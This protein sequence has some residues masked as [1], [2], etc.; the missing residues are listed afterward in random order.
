MLA[1]TKKT[2]ERKTGARGLRSILE[3]TLLDLMYKLPSYKD[4]EKIIITEGF[5]LGKDAPT[6]VY[7]EKK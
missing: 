4:V 5:I 6:F 3:H 7:G 2:V 1:V